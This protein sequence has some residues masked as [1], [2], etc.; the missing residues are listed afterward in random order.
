MSDVQALF[1]A[2]LLVLVASSLGVVLW[3][4]I[5]HPYGRTGDMD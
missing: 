3:D 2:L 4:E 1:L 5:K